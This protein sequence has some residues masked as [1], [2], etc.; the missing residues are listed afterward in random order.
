MQ[1][2]KKLLEE[3]EKALGA[4]QKVKGD[5]AKEGDTGEKKDNPMAEMAKALKAARAAKLLA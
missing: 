1:L 4:E 2:D 5:Q 3:E